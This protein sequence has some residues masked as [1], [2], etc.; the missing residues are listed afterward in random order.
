MIA[1][2]KAQSIFSKFE[3]CHEHVVLSVYVDTESLSREERVK[4]VKGALETEFHRNHRLENLSQMSSKVKR[5]VLEAVSGLESSPQSLAIFV[6]FDPNEESKNESDMQVMIHLEKLPMP[7]SRTMVFVS[8]IPDIRHLSDSIHRAESALI[9]SLHAES[10]HVYEYLDWRLEP[11]KSFTNTRVDVSNTNVEADER[12]SIKSPVMGGGNQT[13]RG[14]GEY[15]HGVGGSNI[16]NRELDQNRTFVIEMLKNFVSIA[17]DRQ[18]QTLVIA[19]AVD[20]RQYVMEHMDILQPNDHAIYQLEANVQ[21]EKDIIERTQTLLSQ[22][23]RELLTYYSNIHSSLKT[24]KISETLDALMKGNVQL[25]ILDPESVTMPD[26]RDLSTYKKALI[27]ENRSLE[28]HIAMKTIEQGGDILVAHRE[29]N[30][31]SPVWT[32]KRFSTS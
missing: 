4:E 22:Q 31:F 17:E 19:A 6:S 24:D 5:E 8:D 28:S 20:L 25:E 18:V 29:V 15:M 7:L 9:L 23:K 11:V 12:S 30:S 21:D 32:V 26:S 27:P 13:F 16:E 14:E 2:Q 10:A 1:T 3:H